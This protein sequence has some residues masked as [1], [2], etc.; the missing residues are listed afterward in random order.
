MYGV[1]QEKGPKQKWTA[2][3]PVKRMI[4][5][6]V[7]KSLTTQEPF[8]WKNPVFQ[9][10]E[11]PIPIVHG[12]KEPLRFDKA[13]FDRLEII[14]QVDQKF[15]A[16]KLVLEV[17][18]LLV[19]IDQHAADERVK[20]ETYLR[21]Y[22]N[23]PSEVIF[24]FQASAE[25]ATL[26][27]SFAKD[28]RRHGLEVVISKVSK[29][30]FDGTIRILKPLH[31]ITQSLAI[32]LLLQCLVFLKEHRH[33][34]SILPPILDYLK[35]KACRYEIHLLELQSCL[36]IHLIKSSVETYYPS[37][38]IVPFHFNARKDH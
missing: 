10:P 13:V 29:V 11:I 36:D 16:C 25:Y 4:K 22:E 38:H 21:E 30:T 35:S 8:V 15:I 37:F 2:P 19:L 5:S 18:T 1:H 14:A 26:C 3:L 7:K 31:A 32:E 27:E 24:T 20:L 6:E 34:V 23:E 12:H 17:G 9:K 33:R 28:L